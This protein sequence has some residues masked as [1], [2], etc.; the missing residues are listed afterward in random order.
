[1]NN[2]TTSIESSPAVS[3]EKCIRIGVTESAM[4]LSLAFEDSADLSSQ[5]VRSKL[6]HLWNT[7]GF[8]DTSFNLQDEPIETIKWSTHATA[9]MRKYWREYLKACAGAT[10]IIH[11]FRS[12]QDAKEFMPEGEAALYGIFS[13]LSPVPSSTENSFTYSW[14]ENISHG[15]AVTVVSPFAAMMID[16]F[17]SSRLQVLRPAFHPSSLQGLEFPYCFNNAGPHE[18]SFETI[19]W[20]IEQIQKVTPNN[21]IIMLSCGSMG[22]HIADRLHKLGHD[23]FYCGGAMQLYFGIMGQRWH[24]NLNDR[25]L[26]PADKLLDSRVTHPELWINQMPSEYIPAFAKSVEGGCY[27]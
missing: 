5:F 23:V 10:K 16:Q 24:T 18:N 22:V 17:K 12:I 8:Y 25:A 27:W 26:H 9:S 15:R 4:L 20:A 19:E 7:I 21:S 11:L 6:R 1:M 3:A 2:P 13:A 14:V